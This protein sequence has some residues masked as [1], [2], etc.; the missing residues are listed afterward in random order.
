MSPGLGSTVWGAHVGGFLR[1]RHARGRQR[2]IVSKCMASI[3]LTRV[4]VLHYIW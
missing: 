2:V 4:E 3:T 1:E